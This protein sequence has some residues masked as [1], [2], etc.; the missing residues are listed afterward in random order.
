MVLN[1]CF[2]YT[3]RDEIAHSISQTCQ[4][5][6]DEKLL[7][8][9]INE[10][11][12]ESNFYFGIDIPNVDVLVRTSGHT[13]L[14]D[15]LI[16][17]VNESSSMIEFKIVNWPDFSNYQYYFILLKYGYQIFVHGKLKELKKKYLPMA[18]FAYSERVEKNVDLKKLNSPP[19]SVSILGH[20]K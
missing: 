19:P 9:Q 12:L 16:W 2:S 17:Q 4:L 5:V 13:R 6:S 10:Q 14:S 7:I 11:V 18:S 8:S 20:G 15:F 3:S 1:V